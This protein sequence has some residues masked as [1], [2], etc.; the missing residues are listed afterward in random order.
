MYRADALT[1]GHRHHITHLWSYFLIAQ[2]VPISFALNFFYINLLLT[3]SS[4]TSPIPPKE[5]P[6]IEP[7]ST[8]LPKE[9]TRNKFRMVFFAHAY[10]G[11]LILAPLRVHTAL[12]TPLIFAIRAAILVPAIRPFE[13]GLRVSRALFLLPL[14]ALWIILLS[15]TIVSGMESGLRILYAI[16]A[17]PAVSALGWDY[18]LGAIS[19]GVWWFR[20]EGGA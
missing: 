1:L 14:A 15:I 6:K 11:L 8:D 7:N 18:V 3:P 5:Q 19:A 4:A 12:F 13:T 10:A 2:L 9:H 20:V 16:N 17:N